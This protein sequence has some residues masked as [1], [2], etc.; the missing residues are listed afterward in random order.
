MVWQDL[1]VMEQ[2]KKLTVHIVFLLS[3]FLCGVPSIGIF[4]VK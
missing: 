2:I 3:E 1:N 4:C